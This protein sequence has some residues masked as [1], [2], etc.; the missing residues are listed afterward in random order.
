MEINPFDKMDT[1]WQGEG[2]GT[3]SGQNS[4]NSVRVPNSFMDAQKTMGL[5]TSII[6]LS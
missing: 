6:E 1:D 5:G 2:Y 3:V 4:N